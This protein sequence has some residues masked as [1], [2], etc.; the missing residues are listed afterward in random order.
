MCYTDQ[1]FPSALIAKVFDPICCPRV[2]FFD[3]TNYTDVVSVADDKYAH[4]AAA[5]IDLHEHRKK[6]SIIRDFTAKFYGT[7]SML[8]SRTSPGD[9]KRGGS[10]LDHRSVRVVLMEYIPAESIPALSTKESSTDLT[11]VLQPRDVSDDVAKKVFARVLRGMVVLEQH[12]VF[13]DDPTSSNVVVKVSKSKPRAL[14]RVAMAGFSFSRVW[15]YTVNEKHFPQHLERPLHPAVRFGLDG[16]ATYV[17]WFPKRWLD[18]VYEMANAYAESADDDD[19]DD[20]EAKELEWETWAFETFKEA[21][22]V[23]PEESEPVAARL[24]AEEAAKFAASA[25]LRAEEAAA[26]AEV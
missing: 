15:R 18:R 25:A 12:G 1:E 21:D 8:Q 13:Q 3:N 10:E 9:S 16:F 26:A 19:N 17:G 4:E 6:S 24:K 5:Y 14:V 2:G 23:M 11:W 20:G 7:F 22:F